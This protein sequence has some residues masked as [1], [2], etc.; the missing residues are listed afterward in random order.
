MILEFLKFKHPF[1]SI[2]AGPTISGKTYWARKMIASW[3]YTFDNMGD[4]KILNVLWCHGISQNVHK[5]EIPNVRIVYFEGLPNADEVEKNSPNLIVIDDLMNEIKNNKY[6]KDLFTKIAHHKD[7]S[8]MLLIQ[9]LF[10]QDKAMRDI[11]LNTHYVVV[12]RGR[13]AS[14]VGAFANQVFLHPPKIV[15]RIYKDATKAKKSYLMFDNHPDSD[16]E[17]SIRTR[18]FLE[19]LP[20]N[21][22][23]ANH[24]LPIIYEVNDGESED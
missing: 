24:T 5:E 8:V 12:M 21:L 16:D 18:I 1:T 7:I 3:P 22:R 9:N 17:F 23:A 20:P 15:K 14:Q 11:N 10:H 6:I 2:V 19:D 13:L 4:K